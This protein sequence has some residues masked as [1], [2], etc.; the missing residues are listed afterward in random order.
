MDNAEQLSLVSVYQTLNIINERMLDEL[1][2]TE[3]S[4]FALNDIKSTLTNAL[5][6]RTIRSYLPHIHIYLFIYLFCII[7]LVKRI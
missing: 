1:R 4:A 2:K 3:L 5:N 6:K 7:N